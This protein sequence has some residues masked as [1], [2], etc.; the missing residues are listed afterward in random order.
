MINIVLEITQYTLADVINIGCTLPEIGIVDS[1]HG[2]EKGLHDSIEGVFGILMT[3]YDRRIDLIDQGTVFEDHQVGVKD[4]AVL[5]TGEVVDMIPQLVEF[6]LG[7]LECFFESILL[8]GDVIRIDFIDFRGIESASGDMHRP[9][10][11]SRGSRSSLDDD[12][13]LVGL[14]VLEVCTEA[15]CGSKPNLGRLRTGARVS[16]GGLMS[17][18]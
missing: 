12:F 13:C 6:Y 7:F 5:F 4:F 3:I 11:D 10:G 17:D 8:G 15:G 18:F 1:A 9:K 14:H 16:P 2:L